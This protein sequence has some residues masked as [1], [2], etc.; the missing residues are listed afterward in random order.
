[1]TMS[2]VS[3]QLPFNGLWDTNFNRTTNIVCRYVNSVASPL[4]YMATASPH[5]V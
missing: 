4:E 5:N 1:M 2:L 3:L